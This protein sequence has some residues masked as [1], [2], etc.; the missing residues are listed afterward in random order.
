MRERFLFFPVDGLMAVSLFFVLSGYVLTKSF[1]QTR[2][3][4]FRNI[5]KRWA[6]LQIPVFFAL[7]LAFGLFS[8]F[9]FVHHEA[10][11]LNNSQNYARQFWAISPTF[12]SLLQEAFSDSLLTGYQNSSL[13]IGFGGDFFS[14]AQTL[15]PAFW[16]LN[17]EFW[18]SMLII[19]LAYL[20]P[21]IL[22]HFITIMLCFLFFP[23]HNLILFVAGHLLAC[24]TEGEEKE[25]P[26]STHLTRNIGGSALVLFGVLISVWREDAISENVFF[27]LNSLTYFPAQSPFHFAGM[28]AALFIFL[29]VFISPWFHALFNLAPFQKLGWISFGLFLLHFPILLTVTAFLQVHLHQLLGYGAGAVI[30]ASLGLVVTFRI[31]ATFTKWVD[32]PAIRLSRYIGG[33]QEAAKPEEQPP[34]TAYQKKGLMRPN[35]Q[36]FFGRLTRALPEYHIFSQVALNALLDAKEGLHWRD[37]LITRNHFDRKIADYVI[38]ARQTFDVV[39]IVELDDITHDTEKDEKRDAMLKEAG[40][41]IIRYQSRAKPTEKEIAAAFAS[42]A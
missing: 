26:L 8:L 29:G 10:V 37:R 7:A 6:R 3:K 28:V 30:S 9:G 32:A 24:A 2:D 21:Y 25:P 12:E 39:A 14:S 22:P 15:S 5:F 11:I 27:A 13:F 36:E 23:M 18:G 38:C 33:N 40:Y 16:S 34:R 41:R 42:P 1:A 17:I 4:P 19:L 20:R 31:A 35:E